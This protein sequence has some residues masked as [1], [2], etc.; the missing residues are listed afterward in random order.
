MRLLQIR[1]S[2]FFKDGLWTYSIKELTA[3]AA[4]ENLADDNMDLVHALMK[5]DSKSLYKREKEGSSAAFSS[6]ARDAR[7]RE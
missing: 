7:P 1:S 3:R 2:L 6:I 4:I 5:E